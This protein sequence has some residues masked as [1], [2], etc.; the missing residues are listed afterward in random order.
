MARKPARS[1]P[2]QSRYSGSFFTAT[3][4]SG[5]FRATNSAEPTVQTKLT[6]SK[7][8]D[9][10]EREAEANA[11]RVMRAEAPT[12]LQ[13]RTA[14]GA[15]SRAEQDEIQRF[16]SAPEAT[17]KPD[18]QSAATGGQPLSADVRSTMEPRMGADFS[19]VRIHNDEQA[20][21]LSNHLSARAFTYRNHVFFARNEYQPGTS[22]GQHLLA[23]ELTHTM[24]QSGD[25]QR[26][27]VDD[28]ID[29]AADKARLIPGF[30]MLTLLL[31]FNPINR[32]RVPRTA[33]NFLRALIELVPGGG[34]ITRV[35]DEHGLI[36]RAAV[37]V[38]DK[39]AI[40]GDLGTQ[41]VQG[42]TRFIDSLS[43]RDIFRLGSVWD[44]AKRLVLEPISRVISFG[45]NSVGELLGMVVQAILR[46]IAA[47]AQG[48]AGYDLLRALLGRDPITGEPV[49]RNPEVLIGG[50]MKLIGQEEVWKN[51]QRGGAVPRAFAWFTGVLSGLMSF[52]NSIPGR[53]VAT[54]RSFTFADVVSVAGA[55]RKIVGLFGGLVVQFGSWAGRQVI[56][57][58]EI[59]F[60]VVA[61]GVMPYL[62]K[63]KAAF[64]RIL[65]DPVTF[66]G[67]LIRA[68]RGGF[69]LFARNIVKH[70]QASLIKWLVGPLAEAGVYI[71]TSFSPL[72]IIKLIA[73]VLG[74]T[75]QNIRTKLLKII[76]EPV[77]A[78]LEKTA[79]ILVT[80]VTEGPI[81]MWEQIKSELT[82]IKENLVQQVISLVQSQIVQ[83]AV[84]KIVS[85]FNPAGA[86]VQ[87]IIAIYK[88]I[89]FL[90]EKARQIGAV[91]A[92][93]IDSISAIAAGQTQAASLRV[94][95]TMARI[96]TVVLAFLAKLIGL[97]GIPA[98]LVGIVTKLR[99][100]VDK[101]LDKIVAK[102]ADMLRKLM[103]AAKKAVAKLLAWW[104]K[105]VP[106][107]GGDGPH[108]LTFQGERRSARLVVQ[109]APE[110]PS[111]FLKGEHDK[112]KESNNNQDHESY[113]TWN[114]EVVGLENDIKDHQERLAKYDDNEAAAVSG[115]K[116]N[117]A[118]KASTALDKLLNE[119]ASVI[120]GALTAWGRGKGTLPKKAEG[121]SIS[122]A[123]FT[124]SQKVAVAKE[125]IRMGG[126]SSL[127]IGDTKKH[128]EKEFKGKIGVET[129]VID[130]RHVVSSDDMAKHYQSV[131]AGK[132]FSDVKLLLEQRG[133]LPE[134]RTPVASPLNAKTLVAAAK[135]RYRAFFGYAK[136]LFLG[137]A[138]VNR[139][140]GK[141]I[142]AGHPEMQDKKRLEDHV[143]RIKRAWALDDKLKPTGFESSKKG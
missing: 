42:I 49:P 110:N 125:H 132:K 121:I 91:V 8:T 86:V 116:R 14:P 31:G 136:N 98:K 118:N 59:L 127:L 113:T 75:W 71:P 50:F 124:F 77:L 72:E 94:E 48:T 35:L 34:L 19:N 126:D 130:R 78:V 143:M 79:T 73:S 137:D 65:R 58:L 80:L 131:L 114:T 97:G 5:F 128:A 54:I 84:T 85:M 33:V 88:T 69:T 7:P 76:P 16:A 112:Y 117:D 105:K 82:Q 57:L 83:A 55:F 29:Y 96:L 92:S 11:S 100:K 4:K 89:S 46:P 66:V 102:V 32:A 30:R 3:H 43:W 25:V 36:A 67:H 115:E 61:P 47:L 109:S 140:L 39:V 103:G 51:I 138:S 23:H 90:V 135:R 122:R 56:S 119:L 44:R 40:L 104:K 87:A 142:D 12:Q 24:Q 111:E 60:S 120:G 26:L 37:W 99:E 17:V 6:V 70:L 27:G 10:L 139:S 106:V 101:A 41:V 28:F 2:T 52:V 45:V 129:G 93:F 63:A 21:S 64:H 107:T 62:S 74:L 95:Q 18:V 13:E 141:A 68:A 22:S 20:H 1:R 53:V 15:V 134:A 81:A 123:R 133:S 108:T 9:P 38:E